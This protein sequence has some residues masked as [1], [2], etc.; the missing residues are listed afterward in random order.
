MIEKIESL[1]TEEQINKRVLEIAKNICK[2]F[3]GKEILLICV[4]KGSIMFT[5]DLS[6]RLDAPT[7]FEFIEA[8]SYNNNTISNGNVVIKRDIATNIEGKNVLVIEDIIDT[9]RTLKKI[10][11]HIKTK[12]PAMLKICALLDKPDR[13]IVDIKADYIGFEIED[14]FVVGYGLDHAQKYRNLP[15]VGIV[16]MEDN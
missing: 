13:R 6:K 5:V 7:E 10:V 16:K 15:F 3:K 9:G 8:S 14:V 12:N 1:I 4:L 2:D 11:E